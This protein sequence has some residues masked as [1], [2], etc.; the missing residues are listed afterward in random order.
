MVC[1]AD[2]P[3]K[4][5]CPRTVQGIVMCALHMLMQGLHNCSNLQERDNVAIK[6]PR[7]SITMQASSFGA[8]KVF[9]TKL[10]LKHD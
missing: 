2:N 7:L 1:A 6:R 9:G 10:H 3:I 8:S 5:G 4:R